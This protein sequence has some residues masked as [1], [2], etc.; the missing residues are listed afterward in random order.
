F[1]AGPTRLAAWT[2]NRVR[3]DQLIEPLPAVANPPPDPG[4]PEAS[5]STKP[6]ERLP[7][8]TRPPVEAEVGDRPRAVEQLFCRGCRVHVVC[9]P[10]WSGAA[11]GG[12]ARRWH[13]N[14]F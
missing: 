9:I 1:C 2:E 6:A 11:V 5:G 12:G 3:V 14:R 7:W 10:L 8:S 13:W 4:E